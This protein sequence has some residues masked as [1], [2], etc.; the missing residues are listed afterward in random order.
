M[1]FHALFRID[2]DTHQW[3]ATSYAS[4]LYDSQHASPGPH[5][6]GA[7]PTPTSGPLPIPLLPGQPVP[8]PN[9]LQ[10]LVLRSMA[11]NWTWHVE[12]DGEW[13]DVIPASLKSALLLYLSRAGQ[14]VKAGELKM[15]LNE[16]VAES[17]HGMD[18]E[19]SWE[20]EAQEG[21]ACLSLGPSIGNGVSWKQLGAMCRRQ[22][23]SSYVRTAEPVGSADDATKSKAKAV[24]PENW[25]PSASSRSS[26]SSTSL[27]SPR[28]ASQAS[29]TPGPNHDDDPANLSSLPLDLLP[30]PLHNLTHLSLAHTPFPS[31]APLIAFLPHLPYL[32]HLSLTHWPLP[33]EV[34]PSS[35]IPT[36]GTTP[37]ARR[38]LV[39]SLAAQRQGGWVATPTTPA[40]ASF[41]G[42]SSSDVALNAADTA[43]LTLRRIGRAAPRLEWLDLSGEMGWVWGL[44]RAQSTEGPAAQER[45]S[46]SSDT[47]AR[48]LSGLTTLRLGPCGCDCGE[49]ACSVPLVLRANDGARRLGVSGDAEMEAELEEALAGVGLSEANPSPH[50]WFHALPPNLRATARVRHLLYLRVEG[51]RLERGIRRARL[52]A[53]SRGKGRDR[54]C[55][56]EMEGGRTAAVGQ[57]GSRERGMDDG[58]SRSGD[59]HGSATGMGAWVREL[60]QR[61]ARGEDVGV[62]WNFE[63]YRLYSGPG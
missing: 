14:A 40:L 28:P 39:A 13:L 2:A 30:V 35:L 49:P 34:V 27:A 42:A 5:R 56:V 21:I 45:G 10:D 50:A 52:E 4:D 3:L 31:F 24:I 32:T 26:A 61:W 18:V 48:A 57:R 6:P 19:E 46:K 43:Q 8:S 37:S 17:E 9:S 15:L 11:A 23:K 36:P 58:A 1:S 33:A 63:E 29:T 51:L 44:A 20:S 38:G 54:A 16:P 59:N 55:V 47:W 22:S 7:R 60:A 53:A 12:N 25:D 62:G 41:D